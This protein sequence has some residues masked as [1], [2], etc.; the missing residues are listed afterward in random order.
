MMAGADSGAPAVL[1]LGSPQVPMCNL[2]PAGG[3]CA[4]ADQPLVIDAPN[5]YFVL[6]RSGSM[7]ALNKWGDVQLVLGQLMTSLG[8][9]ARVGAAVFPDPT[10]GN[11]APGVEV[12]PPHLGDA[13]AGTAGPA[14]GA[15][16]AALRP[17]LAAGG[18]PTAA[19]LASLL[20]GLRALPGKTYVILATDGGPNCNP[21]AVCGGTECTTNLDNAIGC[22]TSGTPN[23]CVPSMSGGGGCLDAQRTIG[24]V[25]NIVA[26]GI[27]VYVVGIPG[28]DPYRN[29]L[30]QLAQAG[31]TPRS[32]E[33]FYYAIDTAGQ[34]ALQSVLSS[35]AAKITASCMLDLDHPPPDP[36]LVNVFLDESPLPQAGPDGWTLSGSTVTI[37]GASCL[38]IQDGAVLDVRVVAGCPT[39]TH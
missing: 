28:S 13:P 21:A 37:Q 20:P 35:I 24:A 22:P 26:A 9:R 30:D 34:V 25:Q 18:T 33:P 23:C 16:M 4:C 39:V 7:N 12:F 1:D 32:A 17:I 38:K 15:L 2:G 5:L 29:L 11:C 31:G 8:P 3:V 36:S 19:T 10:L 27:P 14:Q 6:D